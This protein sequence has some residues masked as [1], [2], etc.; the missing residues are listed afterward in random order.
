MVAVTPDSDIRFPNHFSEHTNGKTKTKPA[1]FDN[2][3]NRRAEKPITA[4]PEKKVAGSISD[5]GSKSPKTMSSGMLN[6]KAH[7][8][9]NT[10]GM[11]ACTSKCGK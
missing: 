6:T 3:V 1:P 4:D 11:T 10:I 7:N 8:G 9:P 5:A 2:S